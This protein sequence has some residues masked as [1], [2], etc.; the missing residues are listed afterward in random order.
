M[1]VPLAEKMKDKDKLEGDGQSVAKESEMKQEI[2]CSVVNLDMEKEGL[3]GEK[4]DGVIG[5]DVTPLVLVEGGIISGKAF[6]DSSTGQAQRDADC[7]VLGKDQVQRPLEVEH[8]LID[9]PVTLRIQ[10]VSN[11]IHL[12][13]LDLEN[14]GADNRR[15]PKDV[16]VKGMFERVSQEKV[17]ENLKPCMLNRQSFQFENSLF[18]LEHFSI[19]KSGAS[20]SLDDDRGLVSNREPL[21][22]G[23]Y[24]DT[25]SRSKY[26][27]GKVVADS[28]G[29]EDSDA[30]SMEFSGA[31]VENRLRMRDEGSLCHD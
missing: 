21:D 20:V 4:G 1:E 28:E 12:K 14:L 15:M 11:F 19:S 24:S 30:V 29:L 26:L 9:S 23:Y 3:I 7:F 17:M 18:Y 27:M 10:F 6:F 31:K 16:L 2:R 8:V 25:G 5:G 22:K 13:D